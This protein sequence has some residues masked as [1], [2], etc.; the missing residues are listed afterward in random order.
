MA[1]STDP[2]IWNQE[3]A[4]P[5]EVISYVDDAVKAKMPEGTQVLSIAPSGS[6]YWARTAKIAT[7]D[8]EGNEVFYFI[9]AHQGETGHSLVLGEYHSMNTLWTVMPELVAR[10]YGYGTYEKMEDVHFFLCSFHELTDDIPDID[11]FPALVAKLHKAQTSPD[12]TFGFPY[13]TFGGRL[14]QLF[15]VTDSW[16]TTFKSGLER[17]F[18][19][20]ENTH[21]HDEDMAQLRKG[22]MEKSFHGLFAP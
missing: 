22:I 21:G 1:P 6:S 7:L 9:K 11:D 12:G 14:P 19:S 15:P 18:D 4:V 13:E 5:A 10:P 17:I 3:I 2:S 16:E 8:S 20:E